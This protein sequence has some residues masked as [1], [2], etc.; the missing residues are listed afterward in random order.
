[1]VDFPKL[2]TGT[3]VQYPLEETLTCHCTIVQFLD[4]R[5]QRFALQNT[6]LKRWKLSYS[7]LTESEFRRLHDFY[8]SMHG[9]ARA[10][11]FEDPETGVVF[12]NCTFEQ[13]SFEILLD[14]NGSAHVAVIVRQES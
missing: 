12:T 7:T 5:E 4:G 13:D 10:F 8:V 6:C 3:S 1:M 9:S 11:S 2:S 14:S